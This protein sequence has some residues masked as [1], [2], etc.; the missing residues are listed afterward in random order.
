M[1]GGNLLKRNYNP[2]CVISVRIS[3]S[4]ADV[5]GLQDND[6]MNK[7]WSP[8]NELS[9]CAAVSYRYFIA[10]LRELLIENQTILL[11]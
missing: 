10:K 2:T 7:I 3:A 4:Q 6:C 1:T 9:L 5:R 8:F 11:K